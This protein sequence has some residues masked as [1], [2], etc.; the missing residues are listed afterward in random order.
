M[1]I[2]DTPVTTTEELGIERSTYESDSTIQLHGTVVHTHNRHRAIDRYA[3]YLDL[4]TKGTHVFEIMFEKADDH[5]LFERAKAVSKGSVVTVGVGVIVMS[6][7]V[8][9]YRARNLSLD[10]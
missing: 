6:D 8:R 9:M 1:T 5:E 10:A 3:I 4:D 2:L 7:G